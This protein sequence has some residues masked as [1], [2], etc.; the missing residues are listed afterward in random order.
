MLL[1]QRMD[2]GTRTMDIVR[3]AEELWTLGV[4]GPSDACKSAKIILPHGYSHL[5]SDFWWWAASMKLLVWWLL[6]ASCKQK[7]LPGTKY[8]P[9]I[10]KSL[11]KTI[12]WLILYFQAVLS[13]L[14]LCIQLLKYF[15]NSFLSLNGTRPA[16]TNCHLCSNA[17]KNSSPA[18]L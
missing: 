10:W 13:L 7:F 6:L 2:F 11:D 8:S 14:E 17:L 5:S 3:Q 18:F 1:R 16:S 4:P 15:L 9:T 12:W